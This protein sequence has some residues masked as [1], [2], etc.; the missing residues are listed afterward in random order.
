V[1][2][3][4]QPFLQRKI[5]GSE[6]FATFVAE[7]SYP[8]GPGIISGVSFQPIYQADGSID[9]ELTYLSTK[10]SAEGRG[11]AIWLIFQAMSSLKSVKF[12]T[13]Y[14]QSCSGEGFE[15][16]VSFY[17]RLGKFCFLMR[18][19]FSRLCVFRLSIVKYHFPRR[20]ST[21]RHFILF[22]SFR[23]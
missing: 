22:F 15:K 2:R 14:C 10:L 19:L 23:F 12:N 20:I 18:I 3:G 21:G 5:K 1:S 13:M 9:I 4:L 6:H 7:V 16:T 11:V 17:H 8:K